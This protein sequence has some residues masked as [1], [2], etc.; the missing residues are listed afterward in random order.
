[1]LEKEILELT[2][3]GEEWPR[4]VKQRVLE[5]ITVTG[6]AKFEQQT[7]EQGMMCDKMSALVAHLTLVLLLLHSPS[8]PSKR[9]CYIDTVV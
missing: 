8:S 6:G 1:M 7:K 4:S 9:Y 3:A 5:E 2:E